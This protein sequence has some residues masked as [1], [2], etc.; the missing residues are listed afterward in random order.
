MNA[1]CSPGFDGVPFKIF[2]ENFK[3]ILP[4]LER[5]YCLV[6]QHEFHNNTMYSQ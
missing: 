1:K 6:T 5:E 2:V 3:K 4:F